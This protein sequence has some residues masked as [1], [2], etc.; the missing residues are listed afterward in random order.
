MGTP[1][2][3]VAEA[4]IIVALAVVGAAITVARVVVEAAIAVALVVAEAVIVA[5]VANVSA[6]TVGKIAGK[7]KEDDLRENSVMSVKD[8]YRTVLDASFTL[9]A[10]SG[11]FRLF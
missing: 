2:M 4:A 5:I 1:A 3:T 7:S 6:T 10:F 9:F 11:W 8:E